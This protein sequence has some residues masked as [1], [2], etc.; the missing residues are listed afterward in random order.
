[1]NPEPVFR[2]EIDL[3]RFRPGGWAAVVVVLMFSAALWQVGAVGLRFWPEAG[4]L[5]LLAVC[6]AAQVG[7]IV[8]S[9]VLLRPVFR[10]GTFRIV[11][12]A[13]QLRVESPSFVWGPAFT[14]EVARIGRLVID[15]YPLGGGEV[16]Y[17]VQDVDGIR[18]DVQI[19]LEPD[20]RRCDRLFAAIR[21]LRPDVPLDDW[22]HG[23]SGRTRTGA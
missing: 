12:T 8:L 23:L 20:E 5:I 22:T 17:H 4:A 6:V 18:Y 9:V 7:L 10:G 11:L 13:D 19:P 16:S 2:H 21:Q 14:L 1:M 3:G 15:R